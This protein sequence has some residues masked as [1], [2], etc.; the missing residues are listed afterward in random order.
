MAS[1]KRHLLRKHEHESIFVH[2]NREDREFINH[3]QCD[4]CTGSEDSVNPPTIHSEFETFRSS[5][6]DFDFLSDFMQSALMF[7]LSLY[8]CNNF[9]RKDVISI[10]KKVD[11]FIIEPLLNIFKRFAEKELKNNIRIF[12]EIFSIITSCRHALKKFKSGY[13]IEHNLK[14]LELMKDIE[15]FPINASI[16]PTHKNGSLIYSEKINKVVALPLDFYFKKFFEKDNLLCKMLLHMDFLQRST[17]YKNFINCKL[18]KRK[19]ALLP[20]KIV[21]PCLLY[22]DDVEIN[23]P[24]GSHVTSHSICNAYISFTCF[25]KK[26][27][28]VENILL[29]GIYKTT[30]MKKFGTEK[31]LKSLVNQLRALEIDDLQIKSN[32]KIHQVH[33]VL[34]LILGDNLGL[35]SI[36]NFSRSFSSN[37]F[38]RLCK[39]SKKQTREICSESKELSRTRQNYAEDILLGSTSSTGVTEECLFNDLPSFHVAE[40]FYVGVMDDIFEGICHYDFSHIL[41]YFIQKMKYF[42]IDTLNSRKRNFNY[43]PY[44]IENI[45]G[46]ITINH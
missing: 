1:F 42:D 30:D 2:S 13:Q 14:S 32:N 46:D 41:I 19:E 8:D 16:E 9:S 3:Q 18:W 12:N 22:F 20:Q 27:A 37:F 10:F 26:E 28:K 33:F 24:L 43:G 23:N 29:A 5:E 7:T 36:L 40:N 6:P 35:N 17:K 39:M 44:D 38:C 15:E 34:G 21:I 45:S 11:N 31:C 25:S 4:S